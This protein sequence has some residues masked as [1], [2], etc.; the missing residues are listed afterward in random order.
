[1][2]VTDDRGKRVNLIPQHQLGIMPGVPSPIPFEV[3]TRLFGKGMEM[4]LTRRSLTLQGIG[5]LVILVWCGVWF[6]VSIVLMP[7]L[8]VPSVLKGALIGIG[9]FLAMPPVIWWLMRSHRQ[10]VASMVTREHYCASCG[11]S[12]RE[13]DAA[14]DGCT[15]CPECGSAWR[16][17]SKDQ[18]PPT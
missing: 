7:V 12:L 5:L 17:T 14:P 8:P 13:I 9:G 18:S 15:V 2:H 16:I 6:G 3:R 4:S 11:Y 1:M 10:E